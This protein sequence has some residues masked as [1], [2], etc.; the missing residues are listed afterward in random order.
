MEKQ[1][2]E[3]L[4]IIISFVKACK[5]DKE[6]SFIEDNGKRIWSAHYLLN[7]ILRQYYIDD[8]H[9]LVSKKAQELWEEI[10]NEPS[11]K[12]FNYRNGV[13]AKT[14]KKINIY[15]GASVNPEP[16]EINV[17]K[18]FIWNDIFH[19]EHTIPISVIIKELCNLK[20]LNYESVDK[21]LDKIYICKMLKEEDRKINKKY[22]RPA[23]VIEVVEKIYFPN[24]EICNW[25]EIKKG[26]KE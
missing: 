8:N 22:D 11:I 16:S 1:K 7:Q 19:D 23:S 21:V 26:I 4:D 20:E 3:V 10:T 14:N 15:K 24:I 18:K 2:N 17:D 12:N 13:V 9:I 6:H 5:K 25:E